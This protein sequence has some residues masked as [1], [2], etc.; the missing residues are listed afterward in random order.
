MENQAALD[1]PARQDPLGLLVGKEN[2]VLK[3]VQDLLALQDQ[4][5]KLVQW[6]KLVPRVRV[7]IVGDLVPR[8]LQVQLAQLVNVVCQEM[9]CL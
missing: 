9:Q 1:S 2:L 7:E 3:V 5:V 6:G 8:V 4:L